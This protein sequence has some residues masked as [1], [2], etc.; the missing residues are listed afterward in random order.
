MF[1]PS[2]KI[3]SLIIIVGF[4]KYTIHKNLEH[5]FLQNYGPWFDIQGAGISSVVVAGL[6]DSEEDLSS[7]QWTYQVVGYTLLFL[8]SNNGNL[9]FV[10]ICLKM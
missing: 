9:V 2:Q 10:K 4:N 6:K 3:V 5:K 7:A 1:S 8:S